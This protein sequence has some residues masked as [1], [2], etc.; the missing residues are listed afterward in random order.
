MS[1]RLVLA[2][3]QKKNQKVF[4]KLF[5]DLYEELVIY[6]NGY[7]FDKNSSEDI[8]QEVF[9]Y[10]WEQAEI[11]EIRDS[12]KSYLYAMVRNRCIN[13]LKSVKIKDS[14]HLLDLN[15]VLIS[16][17]DLDTYSK[18]DQQIIHNQIQLVL[19]EL[20]NKMQEIVRLRFISN[21]KYSEIAEEM[22]VSINTVKTQLKRAKI[23]ITEAITPLLILLIHHF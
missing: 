20:P 16:N 3:I 14:L 12:L 13:F 18:E 9:I 11:L 21:Y 1:H 4:K 5:S 17:Y 8:V 22:G 2:E 15:N 23:K 7:L 19:K 6:A 10:L